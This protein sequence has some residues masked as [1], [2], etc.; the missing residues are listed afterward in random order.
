[1]P[2]E[3]GADG[4]WRVTPEWAPGTHEA[5]FLVDGEVVLPM[6]TVRTRPDAFG[7]LVEVTCCNREGRQMD[8]QATT[9]REIVDPG[10]VVGSHG[11]GGRRHIA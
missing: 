8:D 11:F 9:H 1:M 7:G 10:G 4:V 2:A 3:R 5:T 6:E